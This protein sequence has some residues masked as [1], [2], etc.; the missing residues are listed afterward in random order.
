MAGLANNARRFSQNTFAVLVGVTDYQASGLPDLP[1]CASEARK[2]SEALI[3]PQTW[4]IPSSQVHLVSDADASRDVIVAALASMAA[5]AG[6]DDLLIFYFAGHGQSDEES[7]ILR[8][9]SREQDGRRG[10]TRED[11][12]RTLAD[13][14]ARGVL[15]V[16]DCCG[17]AGFA[18]TAPDFFFGLAG[19]DFRL[20]ISASRAGESS[21]EL[22][23][24][25]SL[26]TRRLLR[27]LRGEDRLDTSGMIFFND[28]FEYLY[29]GVV[30]D[31]ARELPAGTRQTP[32]FAGS[33]AG[34]PLLFLN[35]ELT[36]AQVR[37]KTTRLTPDVVRR[38][39]L[40]TAASIISVVALVLIGYWAFL[41]S[42]QY[43]EVR[44]DNITLVHGYPGL[45]GFG[46]PKDEWTYMEGPDGLLSSAALKVGQPLV[47]DREKSSE[48]ALIEV[49]NPA[50]R[51]RIEIWQNNLAAA[52]SD[53]MIAG[54]D[55]HLLTDGDLT[56]LPYVVSADQKSQLETWV[57]R[58]NP[59]GSIA[60]VLALK[61][62]DPGLA[63]TAY[64]ASPASANRGAQLNLIAKW[65]G[66][67]TPE[68]QTWLDGI[69]ADSLAVL[70]FPQALQAIVKTKGC[71]L[72]S[73][74]ALLAPLRYARDAIFTLRLTDPDA[75]AE[76][77]QTLGGM[78]TNEGSG[79][80]QRPQLIARLAT[81]WRHIGK[82]ACGKWLLDPQWN[83]AAESLLDAAV[84]TARDCKGASLEGR[85]SPDALSIVLH[86]GPQER[87]IVREKLNSELGA[88]A[89][90]VMAPILESG[91]V[92]RENVLRAVLKATVN[93]DVRIYA[94]RRL[95]YLG[96]SGADALE[97]RLPERPDLDRE[98]V[99][100]LASSDPQRAS[101]E[102]TRLVLAGN[103]NSAFLAALASI[104]IAPTDKKALVNFAATQTGIARTI[105]NSLIGSF[106]DA[107]GLLNASDPPV[108]NLAA[109]YVVV[110]PDAA[111]VVTEARK[112]SRHADV[113]LVRSEIKLRQI[114]VLKKELASMPDF[115]LAWR[116][117]WMEHS[118]LD[119]DGIWLGFEQALDQERIKMVAAP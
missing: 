85:V 44:G 68:V 67:C 46:L 104:V 50:P 10:I 81:Y 51:A 6:A 29:A 18:E 70:S 119:S 25:G 62:V 45:S 59:E 2:L 21:W 103:I 53:L 101:A 112:R 17:G 107:V 117:G 42:H 111:E 37:V 24:K 5:Q 78:L 69:L 36:L 86:D 14:K 118:E 9:G 3:A 76:L 88:N 31:A 75:A 96:V 77:Q 49:L 52:R 27:L 74:R 65:D 108:R 35:R 82:A 54:N 79:I 95:R 116:A 56:L 41:D 8:T 48:T 90:N 61:S 106:D 40:T 15:V 60:P 73:E 22:A 91:S 115:A 72:S 102:F 71:R 34:D 114:N 19:H 43:L 16:L 7:F 58:L 84:A 12:V 113:T 57:R 83:L 23:D 94:V 64:M 105:I 47:F 55:P 20:L 11:I 100:W 33:H 92:E 26:F 99:R 109:D 97:Y 110:R 28:L 13:T 89:L 4:A 30:A 93:A 63:I 32:V 80:R 87:V 66:K 38:R 1:A 39:L 98:L